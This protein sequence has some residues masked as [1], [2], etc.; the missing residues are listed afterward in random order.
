MGVRAAWS[1]LFL[2]TLLFHV[3]N[4]LAEDGQIEEWNVKNRNF[5][6]Q[7]CFDK[8]QSKARPIYKAMFY[9]KMSDAEY[10]AFL[11]SNNTQLLQSCQ[12]VVNRITFEYLPNEILENPER[13]GSYTNMLSGDDGPCGLNIEILL[14]DMRTRMSGSR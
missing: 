11:V 2:T 13:V 4:T 3:G 9:G 10:E 1:I 8:A 12:C 7:S 6:I 5:I 14:A